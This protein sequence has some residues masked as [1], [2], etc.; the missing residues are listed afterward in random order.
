MAASR[1]PSSSSGLRHVLTMVV[2]CVSGGTIYAGTY[3]GTLL[4][5]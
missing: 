5:C 4:N 2:L 1:Q 3:A